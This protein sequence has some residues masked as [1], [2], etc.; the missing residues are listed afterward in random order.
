MLQLL[1]SRDWRRAPPSSTQSPPVRA[2]DSRAFSLAEF[3]IDAVPV[4]GCRRIH[5]FWSARWACTSLHGPDSHLARPSARDQHALTAWLLRLRRPPVPWVAVNG[6]FVANGSSPEYV[7]YASG[8]AQGGPR[9]SL[10][11]AASDR[12]PGCMRAAALADEP[13]HACLCRCAAAPWIDW[14]RTDVPAANWTDGDGAPLV[15]PPRWCSSE[16]NNR[17]AAPRCQHLTEGRQGAGRSQPPAQEAMGRAGQQAGGAV[18]A[19]AWMMR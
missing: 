8:E 13:A 4:L 15:S 6:W 10:S 19:G 5:C 17:W 16:P 7:A 3:N 1:S 18:S 12:G 9:W 11:P 2:D 14:W